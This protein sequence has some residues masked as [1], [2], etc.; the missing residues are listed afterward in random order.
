MR[1]VAAVAPAEVYLGLGANVGDPVAQL[2]YALGELL[3]RGVLIEPVC[4]SSFYRTPPW[5]TV[6]DQP[7]F[8]N[9]AVSGQTSL[10]PSDLLAT[11][12]AIE[13]ELGRAGESL[14]W[15]PRPIDLDILLYGREIIRTTELCIPHP[16]LTERAFALAP[17]LEIAPDLTDPISGLPYAHFL[18]LL[19]DDAR[20][21]EKLSEGF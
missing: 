12:K 9:A 11:L 6:A 13:S 2:R 8:I 3:R 7:W 10:S 4:K 5:G 21:I 15:G 18:S 1:P 14:R 16:R 19:T 20:T 17:L